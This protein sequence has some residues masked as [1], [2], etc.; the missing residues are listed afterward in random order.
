MDKTQLDELI[1]IF[2]IN[3]TIMPKKAKLYIMHSY[4]SN[5]NFRV[6]LNVRMFS[7]SCK[8]KNATLWFFLSIRHVPLTK[9]TIP[10]YAVLF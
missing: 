10:H 6:I 8:F 4:T 9:H 1:I 5:I 3:V 2:F 7:I